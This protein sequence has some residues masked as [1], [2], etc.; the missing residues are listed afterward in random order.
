MVQLLPITAVWWT[1][2]SVTGFIVFFRLWF[3]L[4]ARKRMPATIADGFMI[5]T[6]ISSLVMVCLMTD[7]DATLRAMK[8]VRKAEHVGLPGNSTAA[9]PAPR[10][11]QKNTP[12]PAYMKANQAMITE[13]FQR[14]FIISILYTITL[15][16]AKATLF[17]IY[18]AVRT[19]VKR[20]HRILLYLG[21]TYTACTFFIIFFTTL[22]WCGTDLRKNWTMGPNRQ[23]CL[24][25]GAQPVL[26]MSTTAAL[27]TDLIILL[28][29]VIIVRNMQFARKRWELYALAF[30]F[31][32]GLFTIASIL[33]RFSFVIDIVRNNARFSRWMAVECMC[34]L[35][36]CC[37]PTARSLLRKIPE[38]L[39]SGK[40]SG[41]SSQGS[42][43]LRKQGSAGSGVAIRSAASHDED[44]E[45]GENEHV[46]H[47]RENA[48]PEMRPGLHEQPRLDD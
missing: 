9:R 7:L 2:V 6:W 34:S 23:L 16:S 19:V 35:V 24:A 42:S 44:I 10:D 13:S 4:F 33:I 3:M 5:L 25:V 28:I 27:T 46:E 31:G 21:I 1:C 8:A 41:S 45:K 48:V 36:A 12:M 39:S 37:M 14:Q 32:I 22:F 43:P 11:I 20:G 15:W 17:S 30:I 47:A 18:W 38:K 26:L 40:S 29:G